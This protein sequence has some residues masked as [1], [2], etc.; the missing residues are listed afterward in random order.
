MLKAKEL[1][2]D[3]FKKMLPVHYRYLHW[4]LSEIATKLFAKMCNRGLYHYNAKPWLEGAGVMIDLNPKT[5]HGLRIWARV[6]GKNYQ[7][8]WDVCPPPTPSW[9]KNK[10]KQSPKLKAKTPRK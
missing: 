3:E 7:T 6:G 10:K 4:M 1:E 2:Y 5:A 9:F 8:T